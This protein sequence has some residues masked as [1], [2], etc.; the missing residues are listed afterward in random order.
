M[1]PDS[2]MS[3]PPPCSLTSCSTCVYIQLMNTQIKLICGFCGEPFETRKAEYDRQV[4][5]GRSVFYCSLSCSA[6]KGNLE[7]PDR[8]VEIEKRCPYCNNKFKTMTGSKSATFCSRS[9]ASAGSVNEARRQ[10]AKKTGLQHRDNLSISKGLKN[11]EAWKYVKLKKFL[12][13]QDVDYE[14]EYDVGEYIFDLCLPDMMIL[15]EFD[16]EYHRG[17]FA[18]MR[19][20]DK[21]TEANELGW[22]VIRVKVKS[23]TIIETEVLYKIF[24]H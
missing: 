1:T 14:F 17:K 16:G 18:M 23:N 5:N 6:K 3:A 7:R 19:D 12:E 24:K 11:R 10:A 9:C 20:R 4:R 21:D 8:R 15:I 22:N 2:R 13:F